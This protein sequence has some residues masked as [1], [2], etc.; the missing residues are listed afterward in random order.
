MAEIHRFPFRR[1][2]RGD[3]SHHL[4]RFRRGALFASG[5]GLSFWFYPMNTSIVEIP[6]DDREL[7]FLYHARSRDFPVPRSAT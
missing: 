1:H 7:P 6:M 5:R 2:L 3:P 4:L